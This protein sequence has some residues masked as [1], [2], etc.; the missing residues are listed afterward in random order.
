MEYVL[1]MFRLILTRFAS[2]AKTLVFET[3]E[4]NGA[5]LR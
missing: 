4:R 5:R 3:G 2:V 1:G